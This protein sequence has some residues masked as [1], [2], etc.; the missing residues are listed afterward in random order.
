MECEE[1]GTR[2]GR[3]KGIKT[4]RFFTLCLRE[5]GG[6]GTRRT[7]QK[8]INTDKFLLGVFDLKRIEMKRIKQNKFICTFTS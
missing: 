6:R 5:R 1:I 7:P 2:I 4:D 3:K 8:G